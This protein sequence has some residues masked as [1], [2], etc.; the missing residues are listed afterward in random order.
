MQTSYLKANVYIIPF[1]FVKNTTLSICKVVWQ[2]Y[3]GEVG[4]L[5]RTLWLI[6]PRHCISI[7]IKFGPVYCNV[8]VM[9]KKFGMIF[10]A[11]KCSLVAAYTTLYVRKSLEAGQGRHA[12]YF[13]PT[14]VRQP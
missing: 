8:E 1:Q 11:P 6:Y 9:V 4:K 5:Y 12:T 7:S 14:S 3:L 13:I 10:F 2:S